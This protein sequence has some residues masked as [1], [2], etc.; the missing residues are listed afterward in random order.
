MIGI[1]ALL[2]SV[3]LPALGKAREQS[4]RLVCLS[5]I[6]SLAQ[7]SIMY[8]SENKG[9]LPYRGPQAPQPPEALCS[10]GEEGKTGRDM[11]LMFAPYLKGWDINKPNR[12]FHC[13]AMDGTE[14][15]VRFGNNAGPR[16][17][18]TPVC[19]KARTST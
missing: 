6:R 18:P 19:P 13:P 8:A 5:N 3:L 16:P 15:L 11:R 9:W 1:I 2:I 14:M 4:K 7:F 10:V 12:I 17:L